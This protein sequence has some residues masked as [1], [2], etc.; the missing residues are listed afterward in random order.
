MS[1]STWQRDGVLFT[2]REK[3]RRQF[4]RLTR[5]ALQRTTNWW[6]RNTF[7]SFDA[8]VVAAS[9]PLGRARK[10]NSSS[11]FLTASTLADLRFPWTHNQRQQH[12]KDL[13]ESLEQK[14]DAF[15]GWLTLP[16]NYSFSHWAI[17]DLSVPR[18]PPGL[19]DFESPSKEQGRL[20]EQGRLNRN[21]D[22]RNHNNVTMSKE[23]GVQIQREIGEGDRDRERST[24]ERKEGKGGEMKREEEQVERER[25]G[26]RKRGRGE[27]PQTKKRKLSE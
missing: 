25:K 8:A 18:M 24:R 22:Q 17:C 13:F 27:G 14:S 2:N 21:S 11:A 3:R 6:R 19:W 7:T 9:T 12:S 26:N 1:H 10:T 4:H 15:F 20:T 23:E 5:L 16:Q